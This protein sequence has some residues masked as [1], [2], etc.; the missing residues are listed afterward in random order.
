MLDNTLDRRVMLRGA[1][2]AA[3][4]AALAGVAI[5]TP[6][7]A[8]SHG[9]TGSWVITHQDDPP[10]D[11]TKV[12]AVAGFADGGVFTVFDLSPWGPPG[13]GAWSS[14]GDHFRGTLWIGTPGAKQ[15]ARGTTIRVLLRGTV[16][17]DHQSGTYSFTAWDPSGK[18]V[19]KGTGKFWGDR[20]KP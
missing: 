12:K 14:D 11:R 13:A 20:L 7:S 9:V 10:G 4:A 2:A 1:G 6:A 15:G 3:G 16:D 19:E 5:A 8:S 18:Q 17:G